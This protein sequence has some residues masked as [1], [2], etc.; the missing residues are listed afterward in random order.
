MQEEG[1]D[2]QYGFKAELLTVDPDVAA[3]TLLL[4][5]SDV[6]TEQ[7]VVTTAVARQE[8][9]ETVAFYPVL[10]LATGIV[11][12]KDSPYKGPADL[13][14]KE[15]GHFGIDSGTTTGIA[16]ALSVSED[17]NPYEDYE[18]VQAGPQALPTLL[19]QE[20][21]VA[22]FDYQPLLAQAVVETNG[23]YLYN[24]YDFW[25]EH[26]D[27]F[28]PWLTNLVAKEE[29]LRN[30][31]EIAIGVRD[32]WARAQ[33]MIIESNYELLREEPYAS[34]LNLPSEAVLDEYIRYCQEVVPCLADG[35]TEEER[36]KAQEYVGLMLK[37]GLLVEE[38]P[39]EPVAVT[40]E[41]FFA[42]EHGKTAD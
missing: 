4:G 42:G 8:G 31:Q 14:G 24:P 1:L 22:I 2:T 12:P 36:Q 39:E 30:N 25:V 10:H 32:A 5:E 37:L 15:V 20:Q 29:W 33:G 9:Y 41:D 17:I 28:S 6:A 34:F 40:L 18:L 38:M 19:A 26:F 16:A 3:Q 35:W 27:G 13:V 11:V 21:V 23:S 7:D